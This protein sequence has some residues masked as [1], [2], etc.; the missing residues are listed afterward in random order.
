M[1]KV[2]TLYTLGIVA[3]GLAIWEPNLKWLSPLVYLLVFPVCAI[4]LWRSEGRTLQDLGLSR[5]GDAWK[6]SLS[7]AI[8][9]GLIFPVLILLAQVLFGWVT[10]TPR[11]LVYGEYPTY[12]LVPGYI[13]FVL[14]KMFF[15]AAI[16]EFVF[17]GFFLQRLALGMNMVWAVLLSSALW[18]IGHLASMV[19]E[20]LPLFAITLGMLTFIV[21][22]TA[23]SIGY[24]RTGKSLWF[25][26]GLHYGLN[27]SFSLLGGFILTRYQAPQWLVGTPPWMPESGVLGP[28]I[29]LLAIG[30]I[31]KITSRLTLSNQVV[32]E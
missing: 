5:S 7:W 8:G 31:C 19:S 11:A 32:V 17:R 10:L 1:K 24:L 6:Q 29:W 2:F 25:P 13:A 9:L 18:S 15:I 4:W 20:G 28:L 30:V 27:I 22:G 12:I 26:F 16:E 14:V 21:W 3:V 23:L